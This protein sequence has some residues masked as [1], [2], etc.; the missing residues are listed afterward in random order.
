[1]KTDM[2]TWIRGGS[3]ISTKV[4]Q[5]QN[6]KNASKEDAVYEQWTEGKN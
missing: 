5:L 2:S 1:M 3:E 4:V 6:I